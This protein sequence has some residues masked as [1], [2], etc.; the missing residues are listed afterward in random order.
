MRRK[1][2]LLVDNDTHD[3]SKICEIFIE[4]GHHVNTASCGLTAIEEIV[5]DH[6]DLVITELNLPQMSGLDL[7]RRIKEV[8]GSL[9]VILISAN[10]GVTQAVEAMKFGANDFILKPL[11]LKMIEII[12][13]QL[14]NGLQV[15]L[16]DR[17]VEKFT[18]ITRNKEMNELLQT[19]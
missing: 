6:Y 9:P 14:F 3:Q 12:T 15:N 1:K 7:L 17:P 13:S 19:A 18:I 8:N 10:A 2:V 4:S 16:E 5:R 11:T